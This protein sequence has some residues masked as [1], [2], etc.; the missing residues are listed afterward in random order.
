M[1]LSTISL[2]LKLHGVSA[3]PAFGRKHQLDLRKRRLCFKHK[4]VFTEDLISLYVTT[5]SLGNTELLLDTEQP[6]GS[7][8]AS[9]VLRN[10]KVILNSETACAIWDLGGNPGSSQKH[11]H[12][13]PIL[14]SSRYPQKHSK[15]INCTTRH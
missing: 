6:S 15:M 1:Q 3:V 2:R 8:W 13:V 4:L 12:G 9:V 7:E 14:S 11:F 5:F 10:F